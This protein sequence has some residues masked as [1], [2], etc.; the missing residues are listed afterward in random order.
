M[1][2]NEPLD[3]VC[4]TVDEIVEKKR[5][6]LLVYH[7]D[8]GH[9]GW[10]FLDGFDVSGR[11]PMVIPKEIMLTIDPSIECLLEMPEGYVASRS[12]VDEEWVITEIE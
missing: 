6:I 8:I 1:K 10:S 4:I 11:K 2:W 12:S 3:P 9:G 7:E 5:P